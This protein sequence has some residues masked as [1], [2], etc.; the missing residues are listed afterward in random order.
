ML[1]MSRSAS[2][3]ERPYHHGKLKEALLEAAF[4]LLSTQNAS[5]LSLRQIAKQAGVSHAAPY[6]YFADRREL[7]EALAGRCHDQFYNQQKQATEQK[8]NAADRLVALGE[9]YVNF[10]VQY[11]NAFTLVFD[12]ELCSPEQP[13]PCTVKTIEANEQLLDSIV[14][15]A[16]QDGVLPQRPLK[17]ISAAMWA[18]M[19]GLAHLVLL[20][21]LPDEA[22][23]DVLRAYIDQGGREDG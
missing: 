20:G 6:H 16:Q 4:E 11:P 15:A 3:S 18:T 13:N 9:A 1:P 23:S 14:L 17:L 10:A 8:Q 5:Q 22:V 7:L 12:P 2:E 21:H 19:H